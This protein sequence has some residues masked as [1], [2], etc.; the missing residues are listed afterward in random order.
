MSFKEAVLDAPSPVD[1]AYNIGKQGLKGEH[2]NLD[3]L[4]NW[5]E[6]TM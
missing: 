4:R 3:W 2:R 6:A 5:L 1:K